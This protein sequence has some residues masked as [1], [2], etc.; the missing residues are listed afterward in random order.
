MN[1]KLVAGMGVIQKLNFLS[2]E[3]GSPPPMGDGLTQAT[4][5]HL[6]GTIWTRPGLEIQERSLITL[7][8]LIALNREDEMRLHFRGALNLGITVEKLEE[9]ILHVTHYAGWPCGIAANRILVQ[10]ATAMNN[11]AGSAE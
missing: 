6:F 11:E 8:S 1:E 4:V 3:N 7:V 9:V 2:S 10:V 5:E